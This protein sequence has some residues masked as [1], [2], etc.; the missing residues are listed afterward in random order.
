MVEFLV[1]VCVVGIILHGI[2]GGWC[3]FKI[4][5]QEQQE[6]QEQE[7]QISN[8]FGGQNEPFYWM[9]IG[10]LQNQDKDNVNENTNNPYDIYDTY[11]YDGYI[12][13]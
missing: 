9:T 13:F 1:L 11:D 2:I 7:G 3:G 10:S 5:Q 6:Q 4:R 8:N 12:D